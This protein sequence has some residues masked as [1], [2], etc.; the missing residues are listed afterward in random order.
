MKLI[1]LFFSLLLLLLGEESFIPVSYS[2]DLEK[3]LEPLFKN[4]KS[5]VTKWGELNH[6]KFLSLKDWKEDSDERDQ[7]PGWESIVRERNNREIVGRFFQ[8]SGICRVDRGIGFFNASYRSAIYEG[9]EVLTVGESY[10]WIFLFDGTMIRLSPESSITLN[11]INIG[12]KE[13]FFNARINAGNVLWLSRH[14]TLFEELNNRET[15]V[16][17]F[18]LSLYEAQPTTEEKTYDEDRLIEMIEEKKTILNHYKNLNQL[19]ISNNLLTL[20]KPTYAFI[21]TPTVTFMGYNPS[22]EIVSLLGGKTYF[23][24]RSHHL[25][26]L[27]EGNEETANEIL[28]QKRGFENTA[29]TPLETDQWMVI[30]EKGR[31]IEEA[32]DYTHW[33]QMGEFMTKYIPSIMVA[34]ELMLKKYSE[35]A[36]REKY[37]SQELAI[38]EGYRLWGTFKKE[39]QKE[40]PK[41]DLELRF[42]FLKE[43]FRRIETTNLLNSAHFSERQKEKKEILKS[44]EYDDFFFI[45][46]LNKYYSFED[47]SDDKESDPNSNSKSKTLWKHL[48]GIK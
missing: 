43:Y 11:E 13:N 3:P 26:G 31:N 2:K 48:H 36:F 12:Q 8:C 16:L 44:M 10:A 5:S 4:Q 20:K 41:D 38:N 37:N 25:L 45:K 15:D 24:N 7:V 6:K 28:I 39:T 35:F 21:I 47:Y 19:I 40:A 33:L 18:P 17:F 34:R 30:D 23:K 22:L 14:E 42:D 29:L 46:A 32:I 27:Q 9:D 1:W